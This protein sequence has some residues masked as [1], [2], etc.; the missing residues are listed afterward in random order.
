M[1]VLP[2]TPVLLHGG[3]HVN[4][5]SK[6]QEQAAGLRKKSGMNQ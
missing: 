4:K 5:L 3:G 6:G 2:L 1:S